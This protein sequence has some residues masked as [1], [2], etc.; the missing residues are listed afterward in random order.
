MI[1]AIVAPIKSMIACILDD[2][3]DSDSFIFNR[4]SLQ[5]NSILKKHLFK[6]KSL[7]TE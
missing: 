5:L 3:V 4:I 1:K 6:L 7:P 2:F